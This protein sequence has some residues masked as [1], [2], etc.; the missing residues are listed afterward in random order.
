MALKRRLLR[1]DRAGISCVL[2]VTE[3]TVWGWLQRAA[4]Q[5]EES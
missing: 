3:E 2:S 5:A 1:V 4:S